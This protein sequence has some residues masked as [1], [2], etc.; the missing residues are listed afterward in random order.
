MTSHTQTR[1][2]THMHAH[3]RYTLPSLQPGP[4][5]GDA[6]SAWRIHHDHN[7]IASCVC[8]CVTGYTVRHSDSPVSVCVCLCVCMCLCVCVCVCVCVSQALLESGPQGVYGVAS[9][10]TRRHK[11]P[12]EAAALVS[13]NTAAKVRDTH[14]QRHTHTHTHHGSEYSQKPTV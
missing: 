9:E 12:A 14:T 3:T 6:T 2:H 8:V 5:S 13:S 10:L 4:S 7:D 11:S 1:T